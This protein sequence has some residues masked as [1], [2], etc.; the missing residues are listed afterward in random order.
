[1]LAKWLRPFY[2][3]EGLG[4]ISEQY[5]KM[6]GRLDSNVLEIMIMNFGMYERGKAFY[7]GINA[8]KD[9]ALLVLSRDSIIFH[10]R[11]PY[12]PQFD[13]LM[14]STLKEGNYIAQCPKFY[15]HT[16]SMLIVF[17]NLENKHLE[18]DFLDGYMEK[19]LAINKDVTELQKYY[20]ALKG[21]FR[22]EGIKI[23]NQ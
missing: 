15:T 17:N 8:Q 21:L 11:L 16:K 3:R 22:T 18:V 10:K 9:I 13:S 4:A 23:D 12:Q 7:V 2:S 14:T 19:I 6:T 1:V 20:L 5:N